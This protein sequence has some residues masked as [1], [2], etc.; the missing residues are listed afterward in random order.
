[1]GRLRSPVKSSCPPMARPARSAPREPIRRARKS[2]TRRYTTSSSSI[3][4]LVVARNALPFDLREGLLLLLISSPALTRPRFPAESFR[5]SRHLNSCYNDYIWRRH[6]IKI[7]R[8][9]ERGGGDH[10]WLKTRHT[11]SFSD[12]WDEKWMGFRSLGAIN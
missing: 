10:G 6:M 2:R 8:S 5:D 7:R 1:M 9:N 11:F 4:S 3:F 12:Y